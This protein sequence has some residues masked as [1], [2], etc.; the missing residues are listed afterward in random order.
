MKQGERDAKRQLHRANG[1]FPDRATPQNL[2]SQAGGKRPVKKGLKKVLR[3]AL[4]FAL[5]RTQ[6]LD[7]F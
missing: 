4:G 1:I 3:L 2:Q 7:V 6:A 5:L